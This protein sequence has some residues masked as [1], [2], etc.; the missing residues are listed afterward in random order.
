MALFTIGIAMLI[1]WHSKDWM[2]W[3]SMGV[4]GMGLAMVSFINVVGM[5]APQKDFGVV[6]G[7]NSLFR[8]IVGSI[9]PVMAA[10]VMSGYTV[11][12]VINP[13]YIAE[14]T[15]EEGYIMSWIVSAAFCFV[16]LMLSLIIR[17]GKGISYED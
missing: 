4:Q 11:L 2:I 15:N 12:V 10:A 14:N 1:L 5:V 8:I 16:G 7:M 17:P 6:S 13:F 3:I 9:G